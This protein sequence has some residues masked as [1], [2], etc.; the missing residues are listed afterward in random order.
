MNESKPVH[1][2]IPLLDSKHPYKLAHLRS[3]LDNDVPI[4]EVFE[5]LLLYHDSH[6]QSIGKTLNCLFDVRMIL[7]FD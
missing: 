1:I 4:L 6:L 2:H 7:Q 5:W 3:I